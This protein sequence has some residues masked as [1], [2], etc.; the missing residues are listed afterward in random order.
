MA[1]IRS[2]IPS[3]LLPLAL[4]SCG[5]TKSGVPYAEAL[6]RTSSYL[7]EMK[8]ADLLFGLKSD[9]DES[10]ASF[11]FADGPF[12]KASA[13]LPLM[14]ESTIRSHRGG[15][16]SSTTVR[17][18]QHGLFTSR[19]DDETAKRWKRQLLEIVRAE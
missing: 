9:R 18:R 4:A 8:D 1:T 5:T 3:L 13:G 14:V 16:D 15:T 10:R 6:E 11:S 17:A 19:R 12:T 7:E 2:F